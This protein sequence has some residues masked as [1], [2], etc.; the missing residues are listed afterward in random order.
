MGEVACQRLPN[1]CFQCGSDF[2]PV[3]WGSMHAIINPYVHVVFFFTCSVCVLMMG[4]ECRWA[5]GE[6]SNFQI[7][8]GVS[9]LSFRAF[10]SSRNS[11]MQSFVVD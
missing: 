7:V 2:W 10:S 6:G 5:L 8:I 9:K 1:P 4:S 3:S 11:V